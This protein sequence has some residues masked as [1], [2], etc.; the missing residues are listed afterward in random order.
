[1]FASLEICLLVSLLASITLFIRFNS[2]LTVLIIIV[3][4][5]F[6]SFSK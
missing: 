3:F 5:D 6:H 4:I 1:M 2:F